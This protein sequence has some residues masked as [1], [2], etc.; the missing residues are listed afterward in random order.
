[1]RLGAIGDVVFAS[2][3]LPAL[4]QAYPNAHLAW[5]VEPSAAPLLQNNPYLDEVIV[6][7]KGR[8]LDDLKKVDS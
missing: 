2:C 6:W 5:L 3:L 4:R 8:W 7:E 1:V